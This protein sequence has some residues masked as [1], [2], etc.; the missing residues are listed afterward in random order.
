MRGR[1]RLR[2][3]DYAEVYTGDNQWSD[4]ELSQDIEVLS[5]SCNGILFRVQGAMRSYAAFLGEGW[6]CLCKKA[7]GRYL[8]LKSVEVEAG[9]GRTHQVGI[10][11]QGPG[12]Q[13]SFDGDEAITF[14]DGEG[15]Y[16]NGCIGM[17]MRSGSAACFGNIHV[18]SIE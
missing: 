4:Y 10:R 6:L 1:L 14:E 3:S 15:A 12:I 17:A 7:G 13:I 16:L 18:K 8:E 11:V 2:S 5:G 9:G